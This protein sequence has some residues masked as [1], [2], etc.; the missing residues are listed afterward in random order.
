MVAGSWVVVNIANYWRLC[1]SY[2]VCC[3]TLS[4]HC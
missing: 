2:C 3:C 1:I 4:Y